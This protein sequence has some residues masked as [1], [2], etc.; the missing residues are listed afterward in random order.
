MGRR[1]VPQRELPVFLAELEERGATE[2]RRSPAGPDGLVEV[3][4]EDSPLERQQREAMLQGWRHIFL[5]SVMAVIVGIVIAV[6]A[7]L[8][9]F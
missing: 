4:W 8:T 7:F 2:V 9:V 6:I 5:I 3:Q 1:D